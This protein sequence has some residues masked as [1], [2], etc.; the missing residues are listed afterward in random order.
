MIHFQYLDLDWEIL[1][2]R[3]LQALLHGIVPQT[4]TEKKSHLST[5][6]FV[7]LQCCLYHSCHACRGVTSET[8]KKYVVWRLSDDKDLVYA[9]GSLTPLCNVLEKMSS[10]HGLVDVQLLD[11][12][13]VPRMRPVSQL[14]SPCNPTLLPLPVLVS[15]DVV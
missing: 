13:L 14:P 10:Q 6:A 4:N 15:F 9:D 7:A 11:H 1:K 2:T 5:N 12:S 8:H 3:L